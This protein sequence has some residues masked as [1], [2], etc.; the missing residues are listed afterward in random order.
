MLHN[1]QF[2]LKPFFKSSN[3]IWAKE[4]QIFDAF[5]LVFDNSCKKVYLI[6]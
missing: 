2:N 6:L 4:Y 3:G 5:F 1:T